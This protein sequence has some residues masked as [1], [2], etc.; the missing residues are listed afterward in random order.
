MDTSTPRTI[1]GRPESVVPILA[2]K[3]GAFLRMYSAE[4]R[5]WRGWL[6]LSETGGRLNW[7]KGS[8]SRKD[9][10]GRR[11]WDAF[12]FGVVLWL[13]TLVNGA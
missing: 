11:P 1:T 3:F 10:S 5:G 4:M 8:L 9:R 2:S 12:T 6:D 13:T 7:E